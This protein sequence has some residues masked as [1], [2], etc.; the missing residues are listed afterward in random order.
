[1]PNSPNGL[2]RATAPVPEDTWE[3]TARMDHMI[4][5][6]Q[7]IYGRWVV[8]DN[9][10]QSP[11]YRPEV[12]QSNN[13]RQ[14]N[15]A[16]NYTYSPTPTWLINLGANYMNSFNRFSS[17]VVGIENLTQQAGIQGFAHG[18]T[19]GID[20]TAVGIDHRIYRLQRAMGQ[21]GPA[22][23]GSQKCKGHHEPD[24][25]EAHHQSRIRDQRPNDF[26]P[27]RVVCGQ[28]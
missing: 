6:R 15:I 10:Q 13:T 16:L 11:D 7:R 22:L 18:R 26:R 27:A 3:G 17:P 8:Y 23:D 12:V 5:D 24:S 9:T 21:S 25:R 19:R 2:F 20:R 4:T 1:M 28:G 14:H